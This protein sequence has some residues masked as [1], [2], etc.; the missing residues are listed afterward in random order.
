VQAQAT[1]FLSSKWSTGFNFAKLKTP[2]DVN[3]DKVESLDDKKNS[4]LLPA[5]YWKNPNIIAAN[6]YEIK[7]DEAT[8]SSSY[9]GELECWTLDTTLPLN[10]DGYQIQLR[11]LGNTTAG[12]SSIGWLSSNFSEV[13]SDATVAYIANNTAPK[14]SNGN[15]TWTAITGA[16]MYKVSGVHRETGAKFEKYVN[17]IGLTD[18]SNPSLNIVDNLIENFLAGGYWDI[19]VETFADPSISVI[20]QN[21][22]VEHNFTT[23]VFKPVSP[24]DTYK[25]LDGM[26]SWEYSI[27][28]LQTYLTEENKATK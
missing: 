8:K 26:L 12:T 10:A 11:V 22:E 23:K 19:S 14:V 24:N 27:A 9:E 7:Y 4:V 15:I 3:I 13:T 21:E 17:G 2:E 1:S 6:G 20:S 5:L 25:I 18:G 28:D 16:E